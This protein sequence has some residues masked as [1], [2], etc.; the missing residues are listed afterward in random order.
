MNQS[1]RDLSACEA[2]DGKARE[3]SDGKAREASDSIKPGAQAPG[4]S[5]QKVP[6]PR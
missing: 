3:A 5:Y 2:G 4:S 1:L 6:N